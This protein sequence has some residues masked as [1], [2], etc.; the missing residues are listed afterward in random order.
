MD[1][2]I[3]IIKRLNKGTV[4]RR[5]C[6][7]LYSTLSRSNTDIIPVFEKALSCHSFEHMQ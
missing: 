2:L 4:S 3:R 7:L 5:L 6:P 1:A